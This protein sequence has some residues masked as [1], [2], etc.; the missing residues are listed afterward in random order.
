MPIRGDQLNWN[1]LFYFSQ[2]ALHGSVK[3]AATRLELSTTCGFDS[4][5]RITTSLSDLL[6]ELFT[7][8]HGIAVFP[9]VW[10]SASRL[11]MRQLKLPDNSPKGESKLYA[12][13]TKEGEN[14]EAVKRF[15][16][17]LGG[18]ELTRIQPHGQEKPQNR[19]Q[20]G[21]AYHTRYK[22]PMEAEAK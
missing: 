13:W 22:P 2:I 14:S 15:K 7:G 19:K 4:E 8:G 3:A 9:E 11:A 20:K 5:A 21:I 1:Q 10:A 17:L 12:L 18:M 6:V 16:E